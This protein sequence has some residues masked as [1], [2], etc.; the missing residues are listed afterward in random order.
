V[1]HFKTGIGSFYL[2]AAGTRDCGKEYVY[3][4][5]PKGERI[6]IECAEMP[7]AGYAED[8]ALACGVRPGSVRP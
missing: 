8:M 1:A 2:H 3:V 6:W 5:K 4:V 7:F